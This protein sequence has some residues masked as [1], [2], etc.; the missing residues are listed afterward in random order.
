M[1]N[2]LRRYFQRLS[3]WAAQRGHFRLARATADFVHRLWP[4]PWNSWAPWPT[5]WFPGINRNH[6]L[7]EDLVSF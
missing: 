3:T 4:R 7:A 6:P 5:P 1:S 2:L